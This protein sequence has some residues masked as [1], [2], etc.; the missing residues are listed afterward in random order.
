[1][2]KFLSVDN[3]LQKQL[4]TLPNQPILHDVLRLYFDCTTTFLYE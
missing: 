4:I 3:A 1:M 2:E